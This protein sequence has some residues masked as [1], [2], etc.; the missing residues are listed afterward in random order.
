[1]PGVL[2]TG[3]EKLPLSAAGA[4]VMNVHSQ[5]RKHKADDTGSEN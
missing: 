3:S 5:N 4:N 2:Q 1:M